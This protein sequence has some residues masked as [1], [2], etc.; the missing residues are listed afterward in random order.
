[1]S[2]TN[3]DMLALQV[4]QALHEREQP[5]YRQRAVADAQRLIDRARPIRQSHD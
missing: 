2:E 5:E 4:A 1:M 3:C